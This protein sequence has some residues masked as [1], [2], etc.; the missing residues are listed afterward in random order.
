M[1]KSKNENVKRSKH[2]KHCVTH[3]KLPLFSISLFIYLF[4]NSFSVVESTQYEQALQ[5]WNR[6]WKRFGFIDF[7][8]E[9]ISSFSLRCST[10]VKRLLSTICS[11]WIGLKEEKK[12]IR[13]RRF[14]QPAPVLVTITV[15]VRM[16]LKKYFWTHFPCINIT[17]NL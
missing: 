11:S 7:N 13:K 17:Y 4:T 9:K 2:S 10:V 12:R 1:N 16:N 15:K 3:I 6:N 5:K 8:S 14:S